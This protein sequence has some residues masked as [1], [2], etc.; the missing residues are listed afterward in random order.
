MWVY[1]DGH[2]EVATVHFYAFPDG[3]TTKPDPK[4]LKIGERRY[5]LH[6]NLRQKDPES[7][8]PWRWMRRCYGWV[9]RRIICPVF[10]PID[11]LPPGPAPGRS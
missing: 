11:V 5:Q 1:W 3:T 4:A 8:L 7:V 6:T 10:G 2:E 9:Q